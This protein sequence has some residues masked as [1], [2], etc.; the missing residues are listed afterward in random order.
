MGQERKTI[1]FWRN[2]GIDFVSLPAEWRLS[3]VS[4]MLRRSREKGDVGPGRPS[5][6]NKACLDLLVPLRTV[7]TH[8]R[9]A[10]KCERH[11]I[12]HTSPG[13]SQ[14]CFVA[15]WISIWKMEI[16]TCNM[17]GSHCSFFRPKAVHFNRRR[18]S[19]RHVKLLTTICLVLGSNK[20]VQNQV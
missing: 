15:W 13:L 5:A 4:K 6:I 9:P 16:G 10:C 18:P 7:W 1:V 20:S 12:L 3:E 14:A 8:L 2:K 19:D 17:S 11:S